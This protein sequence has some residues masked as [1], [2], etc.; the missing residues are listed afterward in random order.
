[1]TT[2]AK[3]WDL[4][5]N[6]P[7]AESLVIGVLILGACLFGIQT[8]LLFSLASIW[9]ANAVLLGILLVR[10]QSNRPLTWLLAA[11]AYCAADL[12]AGSSLADALLLNGA[13]LAGVATGLAVARIIGGPRLTI[14]LPL[15]VIRFVVIIAAASAGAGIAGGFVSSP[16]LDMDGL[17]GF[18]LWFAAE[19]AGYAI[20][21][22]V[23]LSMGADDPQRFRFLSRN[24]R[25]ARH[26]AA[27]FVAL[28]VSGGAMHWIGGPGATTYVVPALLWCAICYRPFASAVLVLFTCTWILIAS[29]LGLLP[30]NTALS[31]P[32]DASSFRL[33]VAMIA[34]G[35]FAVSIM[36]GAWRAIHSQLL[37]VASHDALT[38]LFN[39]RTFL[40]RLTYWI[41][42]KRAPFSLLMLDVDRFKDINDTHGH[43]A[44]DGALASLADVLRNQLGAD[45]VVGR[46]GGEEFAVLIDKPLAKG[47][48]EAANAVRE[49]VTTLVVHTGGENAIDMTVSIGACEGRPGCEMSQLLSAADGALY[50]AKRGGRDQVVTAT[51]EL[52]SAA[53]SNPD[54]T[55]R[56]RRWRASNAT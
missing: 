34:V 29:P 42:H 19:V 31:N 21:L 12:L 13:N 37:W 40:E 20:V 24:P 26:Q 33:G 16:V 53:S 7:A 8:R 17:S 23:V 4:I 36:S 54:G 45:A 56:R 30:L 38:G 46:L 43:P 52:G 10:P 48:L 27:A 22:P 9:P 41:G 15:D 18:G 55:S 11:L 5:P 25:H 51:L 3:S 39:R 35:T 32:A 28:L 14:S 44:G 50:A 6:Q 1:M 47:G 2:R 49:A